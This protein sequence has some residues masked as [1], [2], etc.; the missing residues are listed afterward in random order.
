MRAPRRTEPS[1]IQVSH[2]IETFEHEPREPAAPFTPTPS[3][4][5]RSNAPSAKS[6]ILSRDSR[7]SRR[8]VG[9]RNICCK[10]DDRIRQKLFAI[11]AGRSVRFTY[12]Y[13]ANKIPKYDQALGQQHQMKLTETRSWRLSAAPCAPRAARRLRVDRKWMK[14]LLPPNISGQLTHPPTME[15]T[16][17]ITKGTSMDF[18]DS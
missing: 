12:K 14:W 15:S 8:T 18:G 13:Q 16:A 11:F 9:P 10:P 17:K 5:F 1:T 2:H 7:T 4:T 3:I 6:Q